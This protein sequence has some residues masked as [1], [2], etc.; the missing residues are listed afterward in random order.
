MDRQT[1]RRINRLEKKCDRILTELLMLR[2][3]LSRPD[4]DTAIERLHEAARKMRRQCYEERDRA[5]KMFN[6]KSKDL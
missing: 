1:K 6:P 5:L 2:R 4:I 3:Q